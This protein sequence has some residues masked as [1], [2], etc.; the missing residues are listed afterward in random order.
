MRATRILVAWA[1][2]LFGGAVLLPPP[3]DG[4]RR[5]PY[6]LCL[7]SSLLLTVYAWTT[8]RRRHDPFAWGMTAGLAGDVAMALGSLPGGIVGFGIGHAFYVVGLRRLAAA[9]RW[10]VAAWLVVATA[11][12][13]GLDQTSSAPLGLVERFGSL[14]Y[15]WLLCA[16]A[17]AATALLVA[18][19]RWALVGL[20][21]LLF[22]VCDFSIG[23]RLFHPELLS[24]LPRGVTPDL[25][26]LVYGPAQA[27]ILAGSRRAS[28]QFD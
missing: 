8:R 3:A 10:P 11:Y 2:V 5:L 22:V 28:P 25:I 27:S 18:D 1:V 7:A 6:A 17:G 26:W 12:W 21:G 4:A 13:L 24:G 15:S 19:R 9:P 23:L 20:G 16:T 14:A